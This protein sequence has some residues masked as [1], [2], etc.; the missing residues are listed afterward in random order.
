MTT[1]LVP[2]FFDVVIV[3]ASTSGLLVGQQLA[4]LRVLVIAH[5]QLPSSEPEPYTPCWGA[6]P[7][8]SFGILWQGQTHWGASPVECL[9]SLPLESN[10]VV[11]LEQFAGDSECPFEVLTGAAAAGASAFFRLANAGDMRASTVARQHDAMKPGGEQP[12]A[13]EREAA[14][15]SLGD[16]LWR[17]AVALSVTDKYGYVEVAYRRGEE[18][19]TLV[20]RTVI[21]ALDARVMAKLIPLITN[22]RCRVF[23]DSLQYENSTVVRLC[24][25]GVHL[26]ASGCIVT[27]GI[28]PTVVVHR[29]L[30]SQNGSTLMVY[31]SEGGGPA[32]G[33]EGADLIA[34]VLPHL[35]Q[36]IR[37]LDVDTVVSASVAHTVSSRA[38]MSPESYGQWDPCE[39]RASERVFLVGDYIWVDPHDNTSSGCSHLVAGA[40]ACADQVRTYLGV[41]PRIEALRSEYLV[42]VTMYHFASAGPLFVHRKYEGNIGYYGLILAAHGDPGIAQYLLHAARDSLWEYQSYFGVTAEDSLLALE[43]LMAVNTSPLILRQSAQRLVELFYSETHQ[44]FTTISEK[45]AT[46]KSCA[47]GVAEYWHG[48]SMDA[49]ALAGYFLLQVVA[50]EER[51]T[52]AACA[53]YIVDNQ[54]QDGLWEGL[55]FPSR[56]VTTYHA[57]RFLALGKEY[58]SATTKAVNALRAMQCLQGSWNDSVIDTAA[59]VLSLVAAGQEHCD[60]VRWGR[61]WLMSQKGETSWDGEAVVYYWYDQPQ[62][63]KLFFHGHDRGRI[64]TAWATLALKEVSATRTQ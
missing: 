10:E 14:A 17:D 39:A 52:I 28:P 22:D 30:G 46:V 11:A 37:G 62:H 50:E 44:A 35:Q 53:R 5:G 2:D 57:V 29:A 61:R 13:L 1:Q 6:T 42:E 60:A 25:R 7:P 12:G 19:G 24:V 48:P 15:N 16:C 26:P 33:A 38:I 64:T 45:K 20:A 3:G 27:P 56:L 49:S 34:Q 32:P 9:R 36:V 21:G 63:G 43:G 51:A 18:L 8:S 55:W 47:Q 40:H 4:G 23:L 54:R 59:A 31:Y 41:S 58:P